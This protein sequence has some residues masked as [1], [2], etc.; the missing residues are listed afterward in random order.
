MLTELLT[1]WGGW[2]QAAVLNLAGVGYRTPLLV[3]HH[4][5]YSVP[6]SS[7]PLK[8]KVSSLPLDCFGASLPSSAPRALYTSSQLGVALMVYTAQRTVS[9][10]SV[11]AVTVAPDSVSDAGRSAG[12]AVKPGTYGFLIRK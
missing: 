6:E 9:P 8:V 10:G 7:C 11:V 4:A 12:G 5:W 3:A 2:L 1:S